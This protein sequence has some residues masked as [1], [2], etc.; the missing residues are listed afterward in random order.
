[1]ASRRNTPSERSRKFQ[2]IT[3]GYS[4]TA[5]MFVFTMIGYAIDKK[6]E[7]GGGWTLAGMFMGLGYGF[8]EL[9]KLI[10]MIN[11]AP[12]EEEENGG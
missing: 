2:A 7:T 5:G 3:F 4:F 11:R 9:W 8:Y 6:L 12:P 10:R 1:M